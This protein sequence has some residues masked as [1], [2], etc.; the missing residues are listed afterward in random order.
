MVPPHETDHPWIVAGSALP[1]G[2]M[3]S[4]PGSSLYYV[5]LC[6]L[7]AL[8]IS[9]RAR[10]QPVACLVNAA[11]MSNISALLCW[12]CT[13]RRSTLGM[14]PNKMHYTLA[15]SESTF[16][17]ACAADTSKLLLILKS[18]VYFITCG[19]AAADLQTAASRACTACTACTAVSLNSSHHTCS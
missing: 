10:S 8:F 6:V 11:K 14:L 2:L 19:A 13:M 16:H 9:N 5:H 1:T 17:G 3:R 4:L 15:V 7:C 18:D 12:S